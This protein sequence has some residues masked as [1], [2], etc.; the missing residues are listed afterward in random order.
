MRRITDK[1][2]EFYDRMAERIRYIL[3]SPSC[4]M[5]QSALARQIG[6]NRPSLCNFINRKDKGIAAHF[7]PRIAQALGVP[8]EHLVSG[9][10][11][12]SSQDDLG[13]TIPRDRDH[14]GKFDEQGESFSAGFQRV[15]IPNTL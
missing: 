11:N 13:S 9:G 1:D 6:W 15:G 12:G 2:I 7:I 8:V 5:T 3:G 14:A 4:S 10:V